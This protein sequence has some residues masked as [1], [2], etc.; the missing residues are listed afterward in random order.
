M[1]IITDDKVTGC[2][3]ALVFEGDNLHV[4][5]TQDVTAIEDFNAAHRATIDDR[6]KCAPDGELVGRIPLEIMNDLMTKGIW[7][8]DD[9]LL[10]WLELPEN[11]TWKMH[12]RRFA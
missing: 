2:K 7:H 5:R 1:T 10:K 9:A 8:D 11:K 6:A 3:T 12:P 4:R